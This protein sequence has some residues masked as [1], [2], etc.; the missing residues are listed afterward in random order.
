MG[1]RFTSP[2]A[3]AEATGTGP[4]DLGNNAGRRPFPHC[5]TTNAAKVMTGDRRGSG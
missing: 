1:A 3:V 2:N 5:P 4:P